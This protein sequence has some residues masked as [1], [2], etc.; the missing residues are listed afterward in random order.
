MIGPPREN[1]IRGASPLDRFPVG[2]LHPAS[3]F[4]SR[5]SI[6]SGSAPGGDSDDEI[7]LTPWYVPPSSIGVS[8][9]ASAD[10]EI[11]I[12]AQAAVYDLEEREESSG[13]FIDR[14]YTRRKL[15]EVC[16]LRKGQCYSMKC[17][18]G[19]AKLYI[20][21]E[22][23]EDGVLHTVSLSNAQGRSQRLHGQFSVDK[24]LFE[25][26]LSC[27]LNAGSLIELPA[28]YAS[29]L[30]DEERETELQYRDRKVFAA[31]HGCAAE[32]EVRQGECRRIKTEF[33]PAVE[34]PALDLNP[35]RDHAVLRLHSLATRD[36]EWMLGAIE[37]FIEGYR[38]WISDQRMDA[39]RQQNELDRETAIRMIGRMEVALKRMRK[40]AELLRHDPLVA[41]S[42]RLANEAML[43]Q[44]R[45]ADRLA[46]RDVA[47][48]DYKWRS[49]QLAFLLTV[50]VSTV[51]EDNEFR[52]SVDLI[53]FATGGG[54][55]EAYL[56]LAAFLM[57]WRRLRFGQQGGGTVAIMRYTL[58]LLTRQQ[59]ERAA[60]MMCA[61]ERI[62]RRDQRAMGGEPFTV[63]FW[64][65]G[66]VSPN[67]SVEARKLIDE[68]RAT[69]NTPRHKLVLI[70]CPWCGSAF[71]AN[72]GYVVHNTGFD[73]RCTNDECDFGR[74]AWPIPCIVVDEALYASPPSLLIST[75]DKFARL[76]WVGEAGAF[77]GVGKRAPDL[78]IQD[79][80][81]LVSGPLGSIAGAYE[82]GV[83]TLIQT[84]NVRPKYIA[85]TATI[86]QAREQVRSLYARKVRVFPPPGLSCDDLYFARTDH[87]RPGRIYLG[88]LAPR[89]RRGESLAPLMAALLT[90]PGIL[91]GQ[92]ENYD[93]L[94]EAW[95]T[96]VVFNRS[97]RDVARSHTSLRSHANSLG[98]LLTDNYRPN[99]EIYRKRLA[100]IRR[101]LSDLHVA[102]LTS[103]R[104]AQDC[105]AT[106]VDLAK[107]RSERSSL[108]VV[109]ATNM[110]SVG[111]DVKRLALMVVN[112]QPQTTGEYI[113]VT[114]RIG[115]AVVPGLV[116]VN[117]YRD[118][119]RSLAHYENFRPFHESFYRFVEPFSVTPFTGQV[120]RRTLHAALVI[121]LRHSCEHL[122][123]NSSAGSIG[124]K[125]EAEC[126]VISRL[127]ER[128]QMACSENEATMR[129][130]ADHVNQRVQE[131]RDFAD[132]CLTRQRM[133]SY[134][135]PSGARDSECLLAPIETP[136]SGKWPTL[137]SMR[138]VEKSAIILLR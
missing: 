95:W 15:E 105:A 7:A 69:P 116:V 6:G 73:F 30:T 131:W 122:A 83:D 40:G 68:F 18:G 110:I 67:R 96:A 90:G 29:L 58:R 129:E 32:W 94:A 41:R 82:A 128:C 106:F 118:Q 59:F 28:A 113:Q 137:N 93:D 91:F 104:T 56:G 123:E 135:R 77:F 49:F 55:T 11:S 37:S 111:L 36:P 119:A 35:H 74:N 70:E 86:N 33:M 52:D 71:D 108:D 126:Q 112:G 63:G 99:D 62:R 25:A 27:T 9:I 31:G 34:T 97:L 76:A 3:G 65:G 4:E 42:F 80:L 138:N 117:Y 44:M 102:E 13:R 88:Y 127:I 72:C 136:D 2:V 107:D 89:L 45:Q 64:V 23:R 47:V 10:A 81:H 84:R 16:L 53:W 133:L 22:S 124:Q 103:R 12:A 43:D 20:R 78:I 57:I 38:V 134:R 21:S 24:Y 132:F 50:L 54:K 66:V 98:E 61:L 60:R 85:S 39:E 115:R 79:E 8:F 120:R 26:R 92:D 87:N 51:R 5:G 46:G 1:Q 109:F 17:L 101:R 48:T 114:S 130:I 125:E 100:D 121:A 19:K 75:I 14:V